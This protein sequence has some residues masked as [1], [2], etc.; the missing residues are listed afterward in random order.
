LKF[1]EPTEHFT[2][3]LASPCHDVARKRLQAGDSSLVAYEGD[4]HGPLINNDSATS[5]E[6]P[7]HLHTV[8]KNRLYLDELRDF[9]VGTTKPYEQTELH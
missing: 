7:Y 8:L 5:A 9:P 1:A 4:E 3:Q 2:I 6:A